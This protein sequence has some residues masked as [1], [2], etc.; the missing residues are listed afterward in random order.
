MFRLPSGAITRSTDTSPAFFSRIEKGEKI[1]DNID[2]HYMCAM[3]G[4]LDK[5][6]GEPSLVENKDMVDYF[7]GRLADKKELV[8]GTLIANA[9]KK[10]ASG[11]R[12]EVLTR[13][14]LKE[15]VNDDNPSK[16]SG[17]A[18]TE[19][20]LYAARGL[21]VLRE[22]LGDPPDTMEEFLIG[23][24]AIADELTKSF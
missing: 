5:R 2:L 20:N 9:I 6:K 24:L 17:E 18:M 1:W 8:I 23:Y 15:I 7:A 13:Q 4:I 21:S 11:Y 19:M 10:T 14:T 3:L 22:K 16:L 12:D